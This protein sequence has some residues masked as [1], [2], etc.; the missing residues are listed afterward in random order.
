M[1]LTY[2]FTINGNDVTNYVLRETVI[3]INRSLNQTDSAVIVID[4]TVLDAYSITNGLSVVISRGETTS[5]DDYV[6]RGEIY[7]I[8][9]QGRNLLLKCNSPLEKLKYSFVTKSY[10]INVDSQAGV[11]SAIFQDIVED[12]GLTASVVDSSSFLTINKFIC[13]DNSRLE[14]MKTLARFLD[15]TFYYDYNNDWVRFEPKGYSTFSTE[16]RTDTNIFNAPIWNVDLK[17]VRNKIKVRGAYDEDT[18]IEYFDGDNSTTDFYVAYTPKI[19]EV[20]YPIS[21]LLVRGVPGSTTTYNYSVDEDR[22]KISFVS[23]PASG[24]NNV[25]IKYTTRIPRPVQGINQDSIDNYGVVREEVYTFNDIVD[26]DD[27]ENRLTKLLTILG[28]ARVTTNVETSVFGI[29]PNDVVSVVDGVNSEYSGEYIVHAVK[30]KYPTQFDI[31]TVGDVDFNVDDII[32]SINERIKFLEQNEVPYT[33]I[34]RQVKTVNRNINY[35]RRYTLLEKRDR[36]GQGSGV[37]ILGSTSFGILGTNKLGDDAN[38]T[39]STISLI[40]G[41]NIYKD[42]IVDTLYDGSGT[43]TWDTSANEISFTS[44]QTRTT[45]DFAIGTTYTSFKVELGSVTGTV[46]TEISGNAGSTW[47]TVTLNTV[48]TFTSCDGTGVRIRFTENAASTAAVSSTKDAGQ[49]FVLP[50][51]KVTLTE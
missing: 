16:L 51:I 15:W 32:D 14:R 31:V 44:G 50:A 6:F 48:T 18:R 42:Y 34:L 38:Y 21:T 1:V 35:E 29:K 9:N 39:T 19:T 47:Q 30:M 33:D 2:L 43:A 27:A 7:K 11:V 22:K 24:T 20:E 17:S 36:S 45:D 25:K 46:L 26:L 8:T 10:D 28:T 49:N 23:A 4:R 5:T 12:A 37:F 40:P 13:K 41:K 3:E